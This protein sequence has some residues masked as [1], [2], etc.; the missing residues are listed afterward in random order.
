MGLAGSFHCLGMCT[1][2]VI[3]S[4][5][6]ATWLNK[7]RIIYNAGRVLTYGLQGALVGSFGSL[8]KLTGFQQYV[9]IGLGSLLIISGLVGITSWHIPL[10]SASLQKLSLALKQSFSHFL[11][12]PS[13]LSTAA[14]GM[15][16]GILPCGLTYLAL[17]YCVSL[18]DPV[19]G[20]WF[21]IIFGLGTLPVM[22]GLTSVFQMIVNRFRLNLRR[23]TTSTLIVIGMLLVTRTLLDHRHDVADPDTI[24]I[25]K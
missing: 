16:N 11:A 10:V 19:D 7:K 9:S 4:T 23:I 13:S 12:R 24:T 17:A 21:M 8:L 1:P 2:L 14:L 6:G 22:L 25:C 20:F 3:V 5:G 18:P 15:L